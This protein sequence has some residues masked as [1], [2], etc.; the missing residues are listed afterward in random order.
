MI[1]TYRYI[2]QDKKKLKNDEKIGVVTLTNIKIHKFMDHEHKNIIPKK[3][4]QDNK[5]SYTRI[6]T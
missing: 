2:V 4:K 1:V 5:L 6:T 3:S